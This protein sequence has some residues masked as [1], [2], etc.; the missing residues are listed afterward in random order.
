MT[1]SHLSFVS[2]DEAVSGLL[3]VALNMSQEGFFVLLLHCK[4]MAYACCADLSSTCNAA[5]EYQAYR[6]Q[7]L[8][9]QHAFIP[10]FLQLSLTVA[11]LTQCWTVIPGAAKCCGG[12]QHGCGPKCS[13]HRGGLLHLLREPHPGAHT[14][15]VQPLVLL[16]CN[17]SAY[18]CLAC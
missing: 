7:S 10:D 2:E 12:S 8:A 16:V 4:G 6:C 14:Y 13:L 15:Q 5:N 11:M 17:T 18:L 3:N 1:K 9:C